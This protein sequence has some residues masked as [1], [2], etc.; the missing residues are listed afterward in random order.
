MGETGR[1]RRPSVWCYLSAVILLLGAELTAQHTAW[2]R[3]GYSAEARKL[4]Q[5][6][7]EW[8]R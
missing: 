5:V 4:S 1:R 8:S 3:A 6:L 2:R 7:E